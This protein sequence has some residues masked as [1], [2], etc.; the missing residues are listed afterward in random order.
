MEDSEIVELNFDEFVAHLQNNRP[1][2]LLFLSNVAQQLSAAYD[3]IQ[4]PLVQ[5]HHGA[6]G[7]DAEPVG[8]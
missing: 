3:Q 7:A 1:A 6:P 2:F 8:R 4:T 5:Q